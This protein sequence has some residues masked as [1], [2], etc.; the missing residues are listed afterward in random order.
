MSRKGRP[1]LPASNEVRV[2]ADLLGNP[3]WY[4][5]L[6]AG[7]AVCV[8]ES[9]IRG[10]D[11]VAWFGADTPVDYMLRNARCSQCG[12]RGGRLIHPSWEGERNGWAPFPEERAMQRPVAGK[13]RKA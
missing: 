1:L 6:H 5:V 7:G 13:G 9:A 10:E 2:M 12:A 8:H 4:R 11:A 3:G